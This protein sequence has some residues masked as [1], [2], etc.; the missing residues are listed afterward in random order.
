MVSGTISTVADATLMSHRRGL[1]CVRARSMRPLRAVDKRRSPLRRCQS[2]ASPDTLT[3]GELAAFVGRRRMP[4]VRVGYDL[5]LTTEKSLDGLALLSGPASR[6]AVLDAIR[7]GND[8]A[9][10]WLERHAAAA[11]E[12][13]TVIPVKGWAVASFA[14]Y[15]SRALDPFPHHHNVI[16]NTVEDHTG[17]RR[18][19]DA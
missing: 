9:M 14:H 4:A 19:L 1:R 16:A 8:W 6:E 15:T 2:S 13:D 5:T 10:G 18:A 12:N 3:R 11:R 7:A 17:V